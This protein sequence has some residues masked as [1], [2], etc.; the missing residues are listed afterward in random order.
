MALLH[1]E[2]MEKP[3]GTGHD[4][5]SSPVSVAEGGHG[6][7]PSSPAN[8]PERP[9]SLSQ[10]AAPMGEQTNKDQGSK[11]PNEIP[12][13]GD[14][15]A[16][17]A[18]DK[19]VLL[20]AQK[21]SP[22]QSKA[23]GLSTSALSPCKV[24]GG[25]GIDKDSPESPFEVIIDKA[26]FDRE[27]K[28]AYKE[29]A[30][31]F[32]RW[33]G[34]T[35]RASSA[36][37]SEASDKV[38]PLR[39]KEAGSYPTSAMLTRQFSHTTAA[40]EEVSRCVS[41]M[42]NFTNEILTW[43][44]VPQVK[45][46]SD[47][48]DYVAKA[49]GL[50]MGECNP[51]IPVINLKTNTHQKT[52]G[53]SINGSTPVSKPQE[54]AVIRKPLPDCHSSVTEGKSNVPGN[55]QKRDDTLSGF[56]V[57]PFEKRVSLDSGE[58]TVDALKG[59]MDWQSSPLGEGTE[60]DSSGESD[61]TV[62]EDIAAA[63]S[64]GSSK[65]QTGQPLSTSGANV[66]AGGGEVRKVLSYNRE[67][68]TSESFQGSVSGSE[69][70]VQPDRLKSSPASTVTCSQGHDR[71][72]M[73]GDVKQ[74]DRS[75]ITEKVLITEDPKLPLAA[76]S[77][78]FNK[79]GCSPNLTASARGESLQEP[80]ISYIDDSSPEDLVAAVTETREGG[81]G[82]PGEGSVLEASAEKT[83]GLRTTFPAEGASGIEGPEGTGS[84]PNTETRGRGLPGAFPTRGAVASL[85]WEQEQLTIRAL[86]ALSERRGE[87]AREK[88][89]SAGEIL[90][91]ASTSAPECSQPQRS[92]EAREHADAKAGS[93]L[94]ISEKP[95]VVKDT[96]SVD[97]TSSL[98]ET[99]LVS[100]H[101]L[102]RLL[103]DVSGNRFCLNPAC[104]QFCL[105]SYRSAIFLVSDV[106]HQI[107][108]RIKT[109][110]QL[111]RGRVFLCFV[112]LI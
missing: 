93:D 48:S 37:I 112:F 35:A 42:H 44:L 68:A 53:C 2:T 16:L 31:G 30:N 46:Q 74:S 70:E 101:A 38:F 84:E 71:I 102:A 23:E 25:G 54:N 92:L 4:G 85:D 108:S 80:S 41:D 3:Q 49:T 99:E 13:R 96:A 82:E 63:V 52:S 10:Q 24:S 109:R 87:E 67:P 56:P 50:D 43:D 6:P 89:G 104:G 64:F 1:V 27:F 73:S 17:A 14:K 51:K 90:Q 11:K 9:A 62:I 95:P 60:A 12:S 111:G 36:D 83:G 45:Q 7:H 5:A 72:V 40:L 94:G 107:N 18:G 19:F 76:Y 39:T 86:K 65:A 103:T 34:H 15:T 98:N 33:A 69:P 81:V 91:Q 77:K 8:F 97:C 59:E 79:T 32:G 57:S 88:P 100:K 110:S 58:A 61:D 20:P 55:V 22:G 66:T 106:Y 75:E 105:I 78:D 28:D 26:A 29:G 47:K 21:P